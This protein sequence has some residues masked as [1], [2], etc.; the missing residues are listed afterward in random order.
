MSN[1]F[2]HF[3]N[4]T[5]VVPGYAYANDVP[6]GYLQEQEQSLIQSLEQS[7]VLQNFPL[8]RRNWTDL[9]RS[10]PAKLKIGT[11]SKVYDSLANEVISQR[12]ATELP[13][14]SKTAQKELLIVNAYL[15]PDEQMLAEAGNMV[16]RGVNIRIITNSLSSQDVPAVNSHYGPYRKRILEA[17]IDLYELNI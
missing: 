12:M 6:E 2:D 13:E 11:S 9:L 1:I 14:F 5:W 7:Q 17:G 8:E 16:Q 4:S 15:I 10:L 3:W